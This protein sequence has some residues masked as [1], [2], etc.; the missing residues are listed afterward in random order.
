MADKELVIKKASFNMFDM[1]YEEA[2]LNSLGTEGLML[3]KI[4]AAF[5][6][7]KYHFEQTDK[8]GIRYSI[9]P[10]TE[11][12]VS[13]EESELFKSAG[14]SSVCEKGYT[15]YC[16]DDPDA[17]DIFTDEESYREY[18]RKKFKNLVWGTA[19]YVIGAISY[20]YFFGTRLVGS[21]G[22]ENLGCTTLYS[23]IAT[24]VM[25][26]SMVIYSLSYAAYLAK[27]RKEYKTGIYSDL[28][29]VLRVRKMEIAVWT[30]L[31][32]LL[33]SSLPVIFLSGKTEIDQNDALSYK[34]EHP[35]L[36]RDLFSDEWEFVEKR[37]KDP[38]TEE[39]FP[40][41]NGHG[42]VSAKLD[43]DYCMQETS[44]LILTKGYTESLYLTGSTISP[45][46]TKETEEPDK[47]TAD[48]MDWL[49]DN[50]DSN[51]PEYESYFYEFKSE[52]K[53]KNILQRDIEYNAESLEIELGGEDLLK[54]N[55]PKG[56]STK[57]EDAMEAIKID[58]PDVDY[59]GFIDERKLILET[60]EYGF[61]RLYLRKGNKVV[62][63]SY[64]G[65]HDLMEKIDMIAE[66]FR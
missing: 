46:D 2:W 66:Q 18:H 32:V 11:K 35:A 57:G 50:Y 55:K 52:E 5:P 64:S 62:Y 48:Y 38:D 31:L 16:T 13:D 41:E 53:A 30:V 51:T 17:D 25:Y 58:V 23:D 22:L 60:N 20:M 3:Q 36:L 40:A 24:L 44:N 42:R 28:P 1:K 15:Y 19:F 7:K 37:I 27:S 56:R 43:Y 47:A 65:K 33:I 54:I 34:G 10:K 8:T 6:G 9:I 61:Q 39:I 49:S 14:W 59:A 26:A 4:T 45:M 12:E 21:S 63:V 29:K